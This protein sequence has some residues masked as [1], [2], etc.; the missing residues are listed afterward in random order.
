MALMTLATALARIRYRIGETTEGF[1]TDAEL[2][3]YINDA[4]DDLYNAIMTINKDYFEKNVTLSVAAGG[5]QVELPSDFQ[6]LKSLRMSTPG[7][8]DTQ[9]VPRDRN[10]QEFLMGLNT[11]NTANSPY[12]IMYDIFQNLDDTDKT[13]YLALS[14]IFQDARTLEMNYGCQLPDLSGLSD[15]FGIMAPH[16]GFILNKAT[17]YALS[18]GPSGDYQNYANQAEAELNRILGV[19]ANNNQQGHSF[20][21]G[22]LEDSF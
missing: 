7:Y 14:P 20:V 11:V 1:W 9:M 3:S 4:K 17:Y 22:F 13:M 8:E 6:R 16:M 15:T 10:T 12:E 18:K 19:L 21:E 2:T 5:K